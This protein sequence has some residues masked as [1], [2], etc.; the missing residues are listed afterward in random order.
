MQFPSFFS[1]SGETLCYIA[2]W[3]DARRSLIVFEVASFL[4]TDRAHRRRSRSGQD[5]GFCEE[6]HREIDEGV[7]EEVRVRWLRLRGATP[8]GV[9]EHVVPVEQETP[10]EAQERHTWDGG[11]TKNYQ[12]RRAKEEERKKE[13]KRRKKTQTVPRIY[14]SVEG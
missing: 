9:R 11:G 14:Y 1:F 7:E 6:E 12:E 5:L 10:K 4:N 8:F 2:K 3:Y 13:R